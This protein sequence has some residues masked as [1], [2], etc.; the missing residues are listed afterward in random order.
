MA[1]SPKLVEAGATKAKRTRTPSAPKPV[2]VLLQAVDENGTPVP[3]DKSRIK[4]VGFER[5]GEAVLETVEGN[6]MP[7]VFYLRGKL[8]TK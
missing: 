2:Y 1:T 6:D 3:F 4:L 8:P 7:N 5:S